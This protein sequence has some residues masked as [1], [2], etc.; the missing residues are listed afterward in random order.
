MG[1]KYTGVD[2]ADQTG[3][4]KRVG[5]IPEVHRGGHTTMAKTESEFIPQNTPVG[6]NES[7]H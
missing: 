6:E 4:R 7:H 5:E 1:I 2:N 3:S